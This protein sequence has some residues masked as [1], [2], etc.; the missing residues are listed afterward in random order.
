MEE[1]QLEGQLLIRPDAGVPIEA[2][3]AILLVG[4][5]LDRIG[6]FRR[7]RSELRLGERSCDVDDG[8][9][10]ERATCWNLSE[11]F[12]DFVVLSECAA[13]KRCRDEQRRD[14][15]HQ[16]PPG[17]VRLSHLHP[18]L[19]ALGT[20]AAGRQSPPGCLLRCNIWTAT[21]S[22]ATIRNAIC[23]RAPTTFL[24]LHVR[25]RFLR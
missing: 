6:K 22:P 3:V 12:L 14:R 4:E 23:S 18:L 17:D 21:L 24:N 10:R 15:R 20:H 9:P 5:V 25:S 1:L 7:R 13:A 16:P 19:S 2:D 11:R 8:R